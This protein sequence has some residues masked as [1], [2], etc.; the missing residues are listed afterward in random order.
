MVTENSE[1][2]FGLLEGKFGWGVAQNVVGKLRPKSGLK[3]KETANNH[4]QGMLP[5]HLKSWYKNNCPSVILNHETRTH[6]DTD[7]ARYAYSAGY[8]ELNRGIC[9]KSRDYPDE[10]APQHE[11][12]K[13]GSHADRFRTQAANK[14]ATTV[15][16]HI[17]KDG[18]YFIHYDPSQCRSLTV[19]E[20][21][22]LQ[23]FPDNYLFEGTRTQQY[24]Q[25]GNAV[26]P[27]LAKQL[28]E[29]VLKVLSY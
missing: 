21:A 5:E 8:T 11:N 16:S 28:G 29:I 17:S 13:S 10:L 12:W 24:V 26:P 20:A 22:R 6:M 3:R 1:R 23:T 14:C 2:V 7:L 9:P 25:V 4:E 19:R 27:Y 18:H 15:T